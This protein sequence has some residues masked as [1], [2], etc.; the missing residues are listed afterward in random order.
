MIDL[1]VYNKLEPEKGRLL[2]TE[3]FLESE[4][5]N[6]SVILLCEHNE[7]GS[8]GFVLNNYLDISLT[9]FDGL[10]EF[11]TKI[12]LGGPVSSKNLYYIHTLGPLLPESIHVG[13]GIYAGGD[14]DVLKSLIA[15]GKVKRDQVRFFLG[16]SGWVEKQLNG[17]LKHNSW[18]VA[19]FE[20]SEEIMDVDYTNIWNDYMSRQGGKYKAFA[21][22]PKDP[23]LN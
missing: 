12:S 18:L 1:N 15:G 22:F 20:D 16:Y 14:F 9:E 23:A 5:F 2:I 13:K 6:R 4:Y 17:E 21:H 11:D 3:P 7:E 8:F 19:D 10:P